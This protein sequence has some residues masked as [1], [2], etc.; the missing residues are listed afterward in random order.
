MCTDASKKKCDQGH[1]L[2]SCFKK[3]K[4]SQNFEKS[5]SKL[6][7]TMDNIKDASVTLEIIKDFQIIDSTFKIDVER[8]LVIFHENNLNCEELNDEELPLL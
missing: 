3:S 7:K 1:H 4:F 5:C 8:W 6:W 2:H